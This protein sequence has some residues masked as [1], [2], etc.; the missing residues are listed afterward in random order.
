MSPSERATG[1]IKMI[2]QEKGFGF[3]RRDGSTD[4]FFHVT[5]CSNK[6]M[7]AQMRPGDS[8]LYAIGEGKRGDEGRDVE[9]KDFEPVGLPE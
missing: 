3:I 7:F 9:L 8:V 1:K 5:E 6:E 4:L 2:S